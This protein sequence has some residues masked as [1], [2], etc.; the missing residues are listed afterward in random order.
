MKIKTFFLFIIILQS[1]SEIYSQTT[2]WRELPGVPFSSRY[3]DV[4]FIDANTGWTMYYNIVYKT[5]NG[6][7]NW[8]SY[9][10]QGSN[11]NRSIG[12][13]DSEVGLIGQLNLDVPMTR[14]TNGGV[15]WTAVN[16]FPTPKP[17]GICGISIVNNNTAY[18]CGTYYNNARAYKTTDKGINWSL[19]FN[20][21]SLAR[22][23]V[24]CYFW[25]EDSGLVVGRYYSSNVSEPN[26]VVLI[27]TNSGNTW[28]RVYKSSRTKE[29]CWK[30]SF[31]SK[32]FGVVSIER[33]TANGLSYYLKTTNG[34]FNW[35]EYPFFVFDQ[36]GIGFLNENTGWI[37]GYGGATRE[38]IDGGLNWHTVTYLESVNR[39]RF[40]NDTL[41]YAAGRRIF[42]YSRD[43]VGISSTSTI[44]PEKFYLSQ[45]YPNPFNPLTYIKFDLPAVGN[46]NSIKVVMK[47][48]DALGNEIR[49]LVNNNLNPGSYQVSFDG[50]Y[51][52]SGIYYY[53]FQFNGINA[54]TKKMLLIK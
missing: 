35:T 40:I 38:T 51:F 19:V 23:L 50:G 11:S 46:N 31:N 37:G 22:G 12:F 32:N 27:T 52:A 41:A 10:Q 4:Y 24:D 16:S 34:G 2:Q 45:N 20:D 7:N 48:Y 33:F 6:G 39:I 54:E 42:K 47:V 5:T 29:W 13:F 49:E 43:P 25:S 36:E 26:S 17:V 15:N 3:E 21:T 30:I 28:Q 8:V 44:V 1:N 9:N 18:A 14:T 53:T